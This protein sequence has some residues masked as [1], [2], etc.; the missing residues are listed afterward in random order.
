MRARNKTLVGECRAPV[1]LEAERVAGLLRRPFG[2]LP[3]Q[4]DQRVTLTAAAVVGLVLTVGLLAGW[5]HE[6]LRW[7]FTPPIVGMVVLAL[8]ARPRTPTQRLATGAFAL[9]A[10][11][12]A[13]LVGFL[14]PPGGAGRLAGMGAF[15]LSYLVLVAAFWRGR[16]HSGEPLLALLFGGLA[17]ALVWVLWPTIP[18]GMRVPVVV[19]AGVITLMAWTMVATTLRGAFPARVAIWAASM[20]VLIFG[21]DF[22]VALNMFHPAF[23]PLITGVEVA[24]RT[25]YLAGWVLIL[26]VIQQRPA[27]PVGQLREAQ[28]QPHVHSGAQ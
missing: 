24:I 7:L 21:G 28:S 20:G 26:L 16:P 18:G 17:G 22:L 10:L 6:A 27:L 19:F 5:P 4:R 13:F 2:P 9:S 1:A 25:T 14:V 3:L 11:G 15:A 12:D 23:T 8:F